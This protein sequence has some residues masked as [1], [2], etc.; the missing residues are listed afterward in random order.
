MGRDAIGAGAVNLKRSD[1]PNDV[2]TEI[3]QVVQRMVEEDAAKGNKWAAILNGHID[4]KLV[5]QTVMTS[6]YG[7][8]FIGAR[9]QIANRLKE[10]GWEDDRDLFNVSCYAARVTMDGL[11][12]MFHNAKDVMRWLSE[13]AGKIATTNCTVSWTTPLG[14]PVSQPYRTG[15]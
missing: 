14:L 9:E 11:H 8:T 3:S 12:K 4:R 15:V 5:K 6:V 1:H 2:Y 7:V 13:C 10:R